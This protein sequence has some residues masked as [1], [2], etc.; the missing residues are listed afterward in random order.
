MADDI[1]KF[2]TKSVVLIVRGKGDS[3]EISNVSLGQKKEGPYCKILP[4]NS[5]NL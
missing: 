2:S 3:K 5:S 4:T 1:A